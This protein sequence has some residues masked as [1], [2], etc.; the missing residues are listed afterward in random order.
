VTIG[1]Q[2][3]QLD[4]TT[5]LSGYQAVFLVPNF[6][7][8]HPMLAS[9]EQNLVNYVNGGGGLVTAEWAIFDAAISIGYIS[10]ILGS[11]LPATS[12]SVFDLS[13][14][15]GYS[16]ST[17]NATLDA[18]LP[19][20]FQTTVA[21]SISG[22]TESKQT[23]EAGATTFFSSTYGDGADGW[24]VGSGRVLSFSIVYGPNE[25]SDP[26]FATLLGNGIAWASGVSSVREP[27][28]VI[29]AGTAGLI[30]VAAWVRRRNRERSA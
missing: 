28:S 18:R 13:S 26:H 24:N 25:L 19:S 5:N 22:G 7:L 30:G 27:S 12:A 3:F 17:G 29:L 16:V 20:S 8:A 2:F 23:A 9:G 10:P 15:V 4:G 21:D 11:I 14:T 6:N 1:P